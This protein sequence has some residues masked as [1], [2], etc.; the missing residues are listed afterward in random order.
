[1][2]LDCSWERAPLCFFK[3]LPLEGEYIQLYTPLPYNARE[4]EFMKVGWMTIY[5]AVLHSNGPQK[6]LS[7]Y[8][9]IQ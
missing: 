5:Y 2:E 6:I 7:F 3:I 4:E 9:R 1:M 8:F